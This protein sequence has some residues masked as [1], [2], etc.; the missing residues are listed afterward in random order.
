MI[1]RFRP[2][3]GVALCL[4][5]WVFGVWGCV[6][7]DKSERLNAPPQGAGRAHPKW[8]QLYVYHNDQGMMADRCIC[9]IHFVPHTPDLS[10]AGVVRLE[11]YAELLAMTGGTL[12]YDTAIQDTG[13][14]DARV[15]VAK[16]F[17][18]EAMP[19]TQEIDV[20]VGLAGGR[21]L[22]AQEAIEGRDVAQ[23]PEPRGTAYHLSG[24]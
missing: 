24:E 22:T 9:D 13:L 5:V 7:Q 18:A 6:A 15:Q 20:V 17:L 4:G 16:D 21:G 11:R 14:V 8:A 3:T 10:G 23:Q 19:S 2:V 12:N 1:A